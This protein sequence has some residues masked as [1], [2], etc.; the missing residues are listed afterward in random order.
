MAQ[1]R[2]FELPYP[3]SVNHYYRRVGRKTLISR[4]GRAYRLHVQRLLLGTQPMDGHLA[5]R[6]ELYPPDRRP[7]DIDNTLKSLCDSLEH[8]GAFH[9]DAQIVWILIKKAQVIPGGK[10]VVR[11]A[12]V[13]NDPGPCWPFSEN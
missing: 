11:I 10:A 13:G 8:G 4:T 1:P 5:V 2:Q 12:E 9:D 6:V 7:R 3:P